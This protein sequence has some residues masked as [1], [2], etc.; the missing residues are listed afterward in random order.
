LKKPWIWIGLVIGAALFIAW[1]LAVYLRIQSEHLIVDR[2]G[3]QEA[4]QRM[5]V[6][7]ASDVARALLVPILVLIYALPVSVGLPIALGIARLLPASAQ[8]R[9]RIRAIALTICASLVIGILA[10]ITNPRYSYVSMPLLA[11]LLG[12]AVVLSWEQDPTLPSRRL[13]SQ[14][15]KICCVLWFVAHLVLTVMAVKKSAQV[16]PREHLSTPW[17]VLVAATAASVS[18]GVM[19]LVVTDIRRRAWCVALMIVLVGIP[20]AEMKNAERTHFSGRAAGVELRQLLPADTQVSI[21][22]LN[23]DLPQIFYYAGVPVKAFGEKRL[24]DLVTAPGNR[25]VALSEDEYHT[26]FAGTWGALSKVTP[27]KMVNDTV[28]LAWYEPRSVPTTDRVKP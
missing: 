22:S 13:L 15:L 26:I 9:D 11:S 6:R 19:G 5:L 20:F 28:Y 21:A 2:S 10:G 23:R 16:D 24:A 18:V 25:W 14:G 8:Q 3:A 7:S 4:Q 1:L 12:A 17:I 27:L